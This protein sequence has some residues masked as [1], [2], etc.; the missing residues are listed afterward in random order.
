VGEVIEI[1]NGTVIPTEVDESDK[2]ALR[3]PSTALGMTSA[4][5]NDT[6]IKIGDIV[7]SETHI[8]CNNCYQCLTNNRHVC[9]KMELFGI[10]RDGGFAQYATIPIRTSWVNDKRIP[11][12]AMSVAEPLGN[13][14][15]V[16]TKA[17]VSGKKVLV[18]GLGPT[19][20]CAGMVA[21][22]YGASEVVG[23]NRREYRR[24]LASEI[25][26]DRVLE[27]IPDS[28]YNSFDAVLEMSGSQAGLQIGFDAARIGATIIAFGIPKQD[29][30][31]NWGKYLI[32]KELSIGSV[33]GRRIWETWFQT[34]DL[35]TS[36]KIDLTKI[37]TH[38]Y[39][40]SEFEEAMKVMMSGECGKVLLEVSRQ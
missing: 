31:I 9:E 26:F 2:S 20:L 8:F 38:R 34:S 4:P 7:S 17:N 29:I 11:L 1:N 15:H 23:V 10:G 18:V 13:A 5:R 24:T 21:K 35:L 40:L 3:D 16:V 22:I 30:T 36:G 25:G 37:I 14:V 33:F 6:A 27:T 19:G 32:N 28:E 12:E 39:K